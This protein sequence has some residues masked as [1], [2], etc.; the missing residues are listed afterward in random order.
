MANIFQAFVFILTI[1]IVDINT[2]ELPLFKGFHFN[3]TN[4]VE[5]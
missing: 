5:F 3:D 2:R 4:K 1:I